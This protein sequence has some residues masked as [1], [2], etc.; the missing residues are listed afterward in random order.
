MSDFSE[1][2]KQLIL[3]SLRKS[4]PVKA[5]SLNTDKFLDRSTQSMGFTKITKKGFTP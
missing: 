3:D 4:I 5:K 2:A 1:Q